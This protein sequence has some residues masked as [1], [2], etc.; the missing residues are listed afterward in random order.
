MVDRVERRT[1]LVAQQVISM[2]PNLHIRIDVVDCKPETEL[3]PFFDGERIDEYCQMV[4]ATSG[5]VTTPAVGGPFI[6]DA[7]GR[8]QLGF[9]L[10]QNRFSTGQKVI[11]LNEAEEPAGIAL[12]STFGYARAT[13]TSAGTALTYQETVNNITVVINQI[14]NRIPG[15]I[16][17]EPEPVPQ[18]VYPVVFE[19][20][21]LSE[22]PPRVG[23]P[24]AQ[25]FFTYD[26]DGGCFVTSIEIY[27]Q[28]KDT[29]AP[30]I[31]ELRRLING[32][33]DK[34]AIA[35]EAIT[36]VLPQNIAISNDASVATKFTFPKPI[37]LEQNDDYCFVV[38]T[39][40]S[41]Y[42]IWTNKLGERTIE[43]GAI[44]WKQPYIGSLFKSENAITWNAE[45]FE[46][47]KFR[48]NTADFNTTTAGNM[49]LD[50]QAAEYPIQ[51]KNFTVTAGSN[52]VL[53]SS[54]FKHD[55]DLSSKVGIAA[56]D[57]ANTIHGVE[58]QSLNGDFVISEILDEYSLKFIAPSI[59]PTATG[60]LEISDSIQYLTIDS[61]GANYTSTPTIT[62][63]GGLP[64]GLGSGGAGSCDVDIDTGTVVSMSVTY[65]GTGYTVAPLVYLIGGGG[66]GAT[67][68]ASVSGGIITGFTVTNGGSGYVRP[69]EIV[70]QGGAT[71]TAVIRENKLVYIMILNRGL[72]YT[73]TPTIQVMGG[74]GTGAAASAYRDINIGVLHNMKIHEFKT[75]IPFAKFERT[76]F[77]QVFNFAEEYQM[78]TDTPF[79]LNSYTN[80][81]ADSRI[82]SEANE[83]LFMGGSPSGQIKF[84]MSSQNRNVSPVLDFS[85]PA[86]IKTA[87][88][89]INDQALDVIDSAND[90][91][92]ILD[93]TVTS[94]GAGYS[95]APT[96]VFTPTYG[97]TGAAATA[98]LT[99][100]AVSAITITNAG[101]GYK[102]PPIVSFTGG[103]PSTQATAQAVLTTFN[104][105]LSPVYGNAE[106]KYFTK[107]IQLATPSTGMVLT[108]TAYSNPLSSF[109]FYVK[110]GNSASGENIHKNKYVKMNCDVD[111]N[112]SSSRGESYDY[113]F[114]VDGLPVFDTYILKCVLRTQTEYDPPIIDSYRVIVTV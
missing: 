91:G 79:V 83:D 69:P 54:E 92:Q 97:G 51:G 74:G 16:I 109:E 13:F 32:V 96:V 28:S 29:N 11:E 62:F 82:A 12:G 60:T 85:N 57:T 104:S 1:D 89:L 87:Y 6:T 114:K 4:P 23:D 38:W 41:K 73:A 18:P 39:N 64:S 43:T 110:V 17:Q 98:T 95:S 66:T 63:L 107:P 25:S 75:E 112:K 21:V 27:V 33:P 55:L 68:V 24:L 15:R 37:R 77:S 2:L 30:L 50:L 78:S 99:S 59:M 14:V 65:A 71:A 40:S 7:A 48:I 31:I 108:A 111:R 113:E 10:P 88:N 101:T 36:Q 56:G 81:G 90:S 8:L 58:L 70:I 34:K 42:H 102:N 53:L 26:V 44:A 105:E 35:P 76:Q 3:F 100:G 93:V 61:Q 106:S 80:V 103:A 86:T 94:P 5:T 67:A 49:R 84:Q 72:G 22:P 45:Q 47:I 52:I 46:D 9:I 20:P 19:Q